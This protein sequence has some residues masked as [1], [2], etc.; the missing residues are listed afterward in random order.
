AATA[1]AGTAPDAIL[2]ALERLT[3]YCLDR[4]I[5]AR[6]AIGKEVGALKK[7][8]DA[9]IAQK[10][11][12]LVAEWKSDMA[13][14]E[15]VVEGFM[16]K[17]SLKKRD[18]KELEEGLF[19]AACPLGLLAGEGYRSYQKHYKRLC[20]HLRD[21][22]P[23]SLVERLGTR[24]VEPAQAAWLSDDALRSQEK[25]LQLVRAQAEGLKNA[26]VGEEV[27]GTISE[28]YVCPSCQSTKTA[29][30]ELQTGW[31]SDHQ[32]MTILVRCLGCGNRWKASDDHGL[33]GS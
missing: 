10:A 9:A 19:S 13:V 8:A 24:L 6:T 31:H 2:E 23:G 20:T 12:A 32:D 14:R 1:P 3:D 28:E 33:G 22:G 26:V 25:Q 29:Y 18:A 7:H 21:R 27:Q 30:V 16:E 15:K 17:G 5:I 4:D 11:E